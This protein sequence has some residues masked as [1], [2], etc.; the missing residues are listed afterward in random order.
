MHAHL[1]GSGLVPKM[2]VKIISEFRDWLCNAPD[3]ALAG[4]LDPAFPYSLYHL[5]YWYG[6]ENQASLLTRPEDW[7][8][9]GA[10]LTN[11]MRRSASILVPHVVRLIGA[12]VPGLPNIPKEFVFD[13]AKLSGIFGDRAGY[14]GVLTIIGDEKLE[15]PALPDWEAFEVRLAVQKAKA[16]DRLARKI[17]LA[18]KKIEELRAGVV[19]PQRSI[20]DK[21]CEVFLNGESGVVTRVMH[22]EAGEN[23]KRKVQEALRSLGGALVYESEDHEEGGRYRPTFLGLLLSKRGEEFEALFVSLIELVQKTVLKD[24]S[25][26]WLKS[27]DIDA[28]LNLDPVRSRLLYRLVNESG[29]WIANSQRPAEGGFSWEMRIVANVDDLASW[30]SKAEY[31][32]N[33]LMSSYDPKRPVFLSEARSYGGTLPIPE[34]DAERADPDLD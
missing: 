16:Q 6:E 22:L 17:P 27:T 30:Q 19:D 15:F 20:L 12:A 28:A 34:N 5:I 29:L 31:L 23:G 7:R 4:I 9:I 2:R 13:E 14:D 10:I 33:H 26:T 11:E 21:I 3:G 24:S 32:H 18:T 25:Q 1:R 8:W